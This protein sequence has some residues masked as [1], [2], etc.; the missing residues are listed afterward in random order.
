MN[1]RSNRFTMDEVHTLDPVACESLDSFSCQIKEKVEELQK[2]K[3]NLS[4][5]ISSGMLLNYQPRCENASSVKDLYGVDIKEAHK[6]LMNM[7]EKAKDRY[8]VS[9]I[10][11]YN[12]WLTQAVNDYLFVATEGLTTIDSFCED[13][14]D[15]LKVLAQNGG[16]ADSLIEHLNEELSSVYEIYVSAGMTTEKRYVIE[17]LT[18]VYVDLLAAE[19]GE[20]DGGD[21][22]RMSALASSLA[23]FVEPS[24]F[25]LTTLDGLFYKVYVLMDGS[26]VLRPVS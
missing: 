15:L 3:S 2:E 8:V 14:N 11:N 24:M 9:Y 17:P 18:V 12:R 13:F 4:V 16:L 7:A 10:A 25:Y 21:S 1:I 20:A 26:T 19:M 5:F 6:N 22:K 23:K